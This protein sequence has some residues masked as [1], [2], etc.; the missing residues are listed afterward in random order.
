MGEELRSEL[1]T[2][3]DNSIFVRQYADVQSVTSAESLC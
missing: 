3:R 1:L 2:A